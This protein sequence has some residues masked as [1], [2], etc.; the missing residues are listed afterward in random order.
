MNVIQWLGAY[1]VK[2]EVY[3]TAIKYFRRAVQLEPNEVK[4]Q[5][6]IASCY[7][8]MRA[9]QRALEV[10]KDVR[11][12]HPNN[13]ECKTI[14]LLRL[15]LRNLV[16]ICNDLGVKDQVDEYMRDLRRAEQ[17]NYN[18]EKTTDD[19]LDEKPEEEAPMP[20]VSSVA[21]LNSAFSSTLSAGSSQKA[22]WSSY[23]RPSTAGV[24]KVTR[25]DHFLSFRP[26]I[27]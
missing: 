4:W 12:K 5:L 25:G 7:R 20:N 24:R 21:A 13:V 22:P 17:N 14:S 2:S 8:R 16:S 3:E 19:I 6:M 9:F 1:Y 26:S 11:T 15:G 18:K 27:E 23:E 10:Y